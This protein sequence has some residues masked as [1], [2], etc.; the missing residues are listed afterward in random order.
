[1]KIRKL[2]GKDDLIKSRLEEGY[3]FTL[4]STD[5]GVDYRTLTNYVKGLDVHNRKRYA[6]I[7]FRKPLTPRNVAERHGIS[8]NRVTAW[9]RRGRVKG[10]KV[11][12]QWVITEWPSQTDLGRRLRPRG[13]TGLLRAILGKDNTPESEPEDGSIDRVLSTLSP[14]ERFVIEQHF[15]RN[16]RLAEIARTYP[17][18]DGRVGVARQRVWEIKERGLQ[19]LKQPAR[20]KI[21][22]GC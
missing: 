12:H 13:K 18:Y 16:V 19:K 7:S 4:L 3:P 11:G 2:I 15:L 14:I 17:R 20:L 1:M 21:L 6:G 10:R 22:L 8:V 9:L 5:F